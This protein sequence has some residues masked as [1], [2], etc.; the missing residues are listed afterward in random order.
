[1]RAAPLFLPAL[2]RGP[3]ALAQSQPAEPVPE[4]AVAPGVFGEVWRLVNERFYDA[5]FGGHDWAAIGEAYR[6]LAPTAPREEL[7]GILNPMLADLGAPPTGDLT[8]P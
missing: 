1:M 2:P 7:P 3:P 8:P 4:A 5:S 6:P